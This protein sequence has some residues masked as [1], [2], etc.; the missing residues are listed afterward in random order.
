MD[1]GRMYFLREKILFFTMDTSV[2]DLD[3]CLLSRVLVSDLKV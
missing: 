1:I 3:S 2:W